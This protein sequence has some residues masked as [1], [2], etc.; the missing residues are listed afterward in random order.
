MK[1]TLINL[2]DKLEVEK[3]LSKKE[4]VQL[5]IEH[6]DVELADYISQKAR[7]TKEK[8]YGKDVY[9]RG[10]IEFTN[11]CKNDC[12]YCGICASNKNVVRYRMTKEQ[13]LECC[14]IGYK[15]GFRTFVLQGGED[16]WFTD[17][18]MTDIVSSIKKK[19]SD[20]AVT[21][22]LGERSFESYKLL[23]EAGADRYLLRHETAN[24]E[25]YSKLHPQK[26]SSEHRKQCLL[27]LKSLGYQF[28]TGF[29][30]GSP[31]QTYE[32]LAE[33]LIFICDIQPHMVG[34]GPFIPHHDTK[35]ADF[36]G[37]TVELTVFLIS[38]LRLMLPY[39]LLP[40]TTAL[41]SIDVF[42]REKAIL[43]GANV[44][45]PNL[46]PVKVRK[47]YMIYDNKVGIE[48]DA[49]ASLENIKRKIESTGNRIVV[50]RGDV[51]R[52]EC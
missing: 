7:N 10:L 8:N 17:E 33:D 51:I 48:D 35:F 34:I 22:S 38:I 46:S 50:S 52:V 2:I 49:V 44:V 39:S 21:L 25:H 23:K 12:Y 32:N 11:Y 27:E 30:V 1:K 3:I 4:F 6:K 20:C 28:G 19:F 13:I 31:Y 15:L 36:K 43:A 26:M 18:R 14:E 9:I 29:M 45:M 24:P 16:K 41:G 47:K 37:G 40:S 5:L 42:G